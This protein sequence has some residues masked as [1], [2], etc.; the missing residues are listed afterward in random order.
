[1][2]VQLADASSHDAKILGT[3]PPG[4]LAVVKITDTANLK[5]TEATFADSSKIQVG[6]LVLAIGNPLGLRSSV[7]NGIV[8][9]L[10]RTVSEGNG[11]ALPDTIQ[12]SAAINPGNSGG[13]L[14][15]IQGRV[16]GIPTLAA[17]DPQLG[18]GAAPGIGFAIPSNTAK[19]I[20]EQIM[21]HGKVIDSHRAYLGVVLTQIPT[22]GVG[23][24]Q[25]SPGSPAVNAGIQPG[26]VLAE[27]DGQPIASVDQ[28]SVSLAEHKPGDT[29]KLTVL[30]PDGKKQRLSVTL[31]EYPSTPPR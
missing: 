31:A 27:I 28:V 12:T 17:T 1:V 10:H 8:S 16:I 13:A 18:G 21:K 6:Q 3:F 9:A 26:S 19:D 7:T 23:I 22:G 4:D 25:V 29:L 20:A 15:D 24:V 2:T 11:A 30:A 14:V 5:L